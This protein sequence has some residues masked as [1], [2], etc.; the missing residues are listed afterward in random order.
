MKNRKVLPFRNFP[1]RFF[2][3]MAIIA[4][5]AFLLTIDTVVEIV[6]KTV[7]GFGVEF[8]PK[9]I[10]RNVA[11]NIML[12]A[13]GSMALMIAGVIMIPVVK[14]AVTVTAVVIV[15]VGLYN[16]YN[17]VVRKKTN[18]ILPK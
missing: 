18:D 7:E 5:I 10:F 11:A 16:I 12:V 8:P 15:G 9:E 1:H 2:S 14:L 13:V 6:K 17:S 4:I 3:V